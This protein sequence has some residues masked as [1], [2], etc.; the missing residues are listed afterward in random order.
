LIPSETSCSSQITGR[1]CRK[2][3]WKASSS[4]NAPFKW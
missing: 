3:S 4:A 2:K 1:P